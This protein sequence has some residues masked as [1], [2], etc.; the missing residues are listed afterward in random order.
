MTELRL[1]AI[2]VNFKTYREV[3]GEGALVLAR[4]CADVARETGASIVVCPPTVEL[5]EVARQVDVPVMAQHLDDRSLGSSTGWITAETVKA[6]GAVGSL[7]NHSEHP[8][9]RAIVARVVENCR[10][11]G[12][13]CCICADSARTAV[14]LAKNNPDMLAVEPPELIGG[15]ISVTSARPE[16][17]SDTVDGVHKIAPHLPVLCGA[18]VKNGA[19]VKKAIELG[20]AGVLLASGIVKSKD[21]RAALLDLVK[22]LP[23]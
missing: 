10:R 7:V 22:G 13:V 18:G 9:P 8:L 11:N 4:T 2:I 1:P 19:D 21:P 23:I 12:L 3:E 6:A 20:A 17:V 15:D 5:A 14:Q 16:V